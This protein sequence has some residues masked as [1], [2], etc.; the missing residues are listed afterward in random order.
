MKT[1]RSEWR[2]WK[3]NKLWTVQSILIWDRHALRVTGW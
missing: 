2:E 3:E 1:N